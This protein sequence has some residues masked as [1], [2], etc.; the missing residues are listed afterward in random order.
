MDGYRVITGGIKGGILGRR[1]A[2][3]ENQICVAPRDYFH[4]GRGEISG[5]ADVDVAASSFRPRFITPE[6]NKE[7]SCA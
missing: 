5:D 4:G 7:F 2:R 6:N 1:N 3:R